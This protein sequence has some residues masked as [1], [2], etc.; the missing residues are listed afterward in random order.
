MDDTNIK[1]HYDES[2]LSYLFSRHFMN[3]SRKEIK[4]LIDK[5]SRTVGKHNL[6]LIKENADLALCG[7]SDVD[8]TSNQAKIQV[9]LSTSSGSP[10]TLSP[11]ELRSGSFLSKIISFLLY[12]GFEKNNFHK[13]TYCTP[14]SDR[15]M[16]DTLEKSLWCRE[17]CLTDHYYENGIYEDA[18]LY[19]ITRDQFFSACIGYIPYLTGYL[20]VKAT[21]DAVFGI[22][23]IKEGEELPSESNVTFARNKNI[24]DDQKVVKAPEMKET[25]FYP[26]NNY[27]YVSEASRQLIEYINKVRTR[28]N[29]PFEYSEGTAF[30]KQVWE[31]TIK[32]PYGQ[33]RTYEE[34]ALQLIPENGDR[35][36]N[37]RLLS[38]AVGTA[39]GKNAIMIAIPCH[40]VIGKNGKLKGF[41]GGLE[42][43]DYLLSHEILQI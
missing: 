1:K 7:F 15:N 27:F 26:E 40:R 4:H 29:L 5:M 42:V 18:F 32:I 28:F 36:V 11:S 17:G 43:K 39:L 6:F 13:L 30:Q 19:G 24:C 31:A 21:N 38:R 34:I 37:F 23:I 35:E 41:A 9:L 3:K 14:A 12:E 33:T 25:A 10:E 22:S 8:S 20:I 16:T 2:D